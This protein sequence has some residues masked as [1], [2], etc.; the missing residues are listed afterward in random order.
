MRKKR[1]NSTLPLAISIATAATIMGLV[2][3]WLNN[4]NKHSEERAM[5]S[6][7]MLP[8]ATANEVPPWEADTNPLISDSDWKK[9]MRQYFKETAIKAYAVI[10]GLRGAWS[11]DKAGEPAFGTFWTPQGLAENSRYIFMSAYDGQRNKNSLIFIIDKSSNKYI[12]SI[13]L[14]CI[15]HVGG[16][17][18]DEERR[19]LWVA[20]DTN[21]HAKISAIKEEAIE[22][23]DARVSQ[24]AIDFDIEIS[25]PWLEQTSSISLANNAMFI[26]N[27]SF[28]KRDSTI[29]SFPLY[30][31]DKTISI[32]TAP[33]K[34][35]SYTLTEDDVSISDGF[36]YT[37]GLAVHK[38]LAIFSTSYHT[39]DSELII[40]RK[41]RGPRNDSGLGNWIFKLESII[42]LPPYLEQIVLD[43][44]HNTLL[45]LFESGATEYRHAT[46]RIID[47]IVRIGLP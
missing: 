4:T 21:R 27:F 38:S 34:G 13:I 33:K 45:V 35:I 40:T 24:K 11:I 15:S 7:K 5:G 6:T 30:A 44:E 36:P 31:L 9:R 28:N 17:A 39:Q 3:F 26:P 42:K 23:Y 19:L 14:P 22:Q 2:S 12:K 20:S 18:Y 47:R 1:N 8:N 41:T 37:Q 25:L 46:N 10:P 16:L 29:V 32:P 43:T